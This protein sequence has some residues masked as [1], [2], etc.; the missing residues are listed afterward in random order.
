MSALFNLPFTP[1]NPTPLS[2]PDGTELQYVGKIYMY[3]DKN[4]NM[5]LLTLLC[6][7]NE[8][9]IALAGKRLVNF[10]S[11]QFGRQ[12]DGYARVNPSQAYPIWDQHTTTVAVHQLC[13]LVLEGPCLCTTPLVGDATNVITALDW[14]VSLTAAASTSTTAGRIVGADFTGATSLL[15]NQIIYKI[16]QALSTKST[17]NTGADILV[18]ISR[19][20]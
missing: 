16:G 3:P 15:A 9:S 20:W 13:Y 12:I 14:L 4:Y 1:D 7:Q 17:S 10:K 6:V 18:N 5:G 11:G 8:A 2:S 19:R